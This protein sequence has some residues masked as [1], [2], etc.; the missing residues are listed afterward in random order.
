M[1]LNPASILIAVVAFAIAFGVAKLITLRKRR[2][3]EHKQQQ[4]VRQ[5]E[6][7]QVRRVRERRT[8]R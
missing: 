2:R 7:R 4:L 8:G 6:S 5:A 1:N 3:K